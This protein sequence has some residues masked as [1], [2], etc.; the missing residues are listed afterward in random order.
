MNITRINSHDKEDYLAIVKEEIR[1]YLTK[2]GISDA[3][4]FALLGTISENIDSWPDIITALT[5]LGAGFYGA[6]CG[7]V[8]CML[9]S[10]KGRIED[11]YTVL[12]DRSDLIDYL[13]QK[14]LKLK[15]LNKYK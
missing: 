3:L 12:Y 10:E 11:N 6:G 4:A 5:A 14:T 15:K 7:L 2:A 9:L 8:V 13:E 1:E